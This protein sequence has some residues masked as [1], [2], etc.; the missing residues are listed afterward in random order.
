VGSLIFLRTSGCKIAIDSLAS[1]TNE[2]AGVVRAHLVDAASKQRIRFSSKPEV[3]VVLR[4]QPAW[5]TEDQVWPADF[6]EGSTFVLRAAIPDRTYSVSVESKDPTISA[7]PGLTVLNVT[8]GEMV[9]IDLPVDIT[10][11]GGAKD[12]KP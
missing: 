5:S 11:P 3:S 4:S 9:E 10:Q 2:E 1:G 8:P 7:R 12:R 6:T